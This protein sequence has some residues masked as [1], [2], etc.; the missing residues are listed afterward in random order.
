M[1][2]LFLLCVP[3]QPL[4]NFLGGYLKKPF[5]LPLIWHISVGVILFTAVRLYH[6]EECRR[7][8]QL[9]EQ[10]DE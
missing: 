2:L 4:I 1:K 8:R 6:R 3:L 7:M 5:Q 9:K 10:E